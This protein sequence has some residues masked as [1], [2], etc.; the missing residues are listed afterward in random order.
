[1]NSWTPPVSKCPAILQWNGLRGYT[2]VKT[3]LFPLPCLPSHSSVCLD[4]TV[5]AFDLM[6]LSVTGNHTGPQQNWGD[7]MEFQF[8]QKKQGRVG[9][10]E[11]CFFEWISKCWSDRNGNTTLFTWSTSVLNRDKFSFQEEGP[12]KWKLKINRL[13]ANSCQPGLFVCPTKHFLSL[14]LIK[15][16]IKRLRN[17]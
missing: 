1:M 11:V 10:A 17:F 16:N 5:N 12:F 7:A 4:S 3:N 6:S 8:P 15:S 2:L 9:L 13:W 14:H